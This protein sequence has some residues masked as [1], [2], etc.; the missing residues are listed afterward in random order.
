[1]RG[2]REHAEEAIT[3]IEHA[4]RYAAEHKRH[5]RWMYRAFLQDIRRLDI[6]GRCLEIGAGAAIL[7]VMMAEQNPH[8][9]ITATDLS[10]DM[11]AVAREYIKEKGLT[12]RVEYRVVDVNDETALER[13]GRFEMVYSTFSLHHWK[14]PLASINNLWKMVGNGGLL[15]IHDMKRIWWSV[16]LPLG[17]GDRESIRASY[18]ARE[19]KNLLQTLGIDEYEVK[20]LFPLFLQSLIVRK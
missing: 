5:A 11:A 12:E 18:T 4:R 10:A 19:I 9:Q 17:A 16:F 14:D 15:Y 1:M 8:I 2:R 13:L 20:T 3:G 6:S 7:A